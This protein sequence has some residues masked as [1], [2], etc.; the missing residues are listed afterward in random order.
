M[1][2]AGMTAGWQAV[3]A[4][5]WLSAFWV[6]A[7]LRDDHRIGPGEQQPRLPVGEPH[8][9]RRLPSH[10]VDLDDF[11]G[12]VRASDGV[13]VNANL[14]TDRCFHDRLPRRCDFWCAASLSTPPTRSPPS[15]DAVRLDR[16]RA[17]AGLR[18]RGVHSSLYRQGTLPHAGRRP[19]WLP[20][21]ETGLVSAPH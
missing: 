16:S 19:A 5:R 8:Q 4:A 20:G 10:S 15:T 21:Y 17:L 9:V 18:C 1:G 14:V 11:A 3:P 2:A 6:A 13:S 12:L 7:L